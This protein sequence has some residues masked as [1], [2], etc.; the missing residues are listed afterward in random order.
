MSTIFA[1][2]LCGA[3]LSGADLTDAKVTPEQL[4]K[5]KSLKGATMPDGS[6][7]P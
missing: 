2:E 5:A 7:R 6:I 4:D 1:V 3:N